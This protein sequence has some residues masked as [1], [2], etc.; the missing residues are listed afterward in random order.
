MNVQEYSEKAMRTADPINS[1]SKTAMMVLTGEQVQLTLATLGLCGESGEIAEAV[2]K[3]IFHD[4]PLDEEKLAKEA[5][6]VLW[7]LN[8]LSVRCLGKGLDQIMD[9]NIEKLSKR[10]PE[11][12]F[13]SERSLNRA[14][15]DV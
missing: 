13:S 11:G 8:Y 6:D 10:Y 15:G 4:H 1:P 3:H 5:G 9:L 12:F 14:K 2:K 7:Y